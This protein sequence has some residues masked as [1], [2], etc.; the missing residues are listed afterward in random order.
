[1]KK[2]ILITSLIFGFAMQLFAQTTYPCDIT[3][4]GISLKNAVGDPIPRISVGGNGVANFVIT[5]QGVGSNGSPCSYPVGKVKVTVSFV[6]SNY[7]SYFFAYAGQPSF[8]TLKYDWVYD[9][10]N[11]QL[12]G[13]NSVPIPST[14]AGGAEIVNVPIVGIA[15]GTT[16]LPMS[17]QILPGLSGDNTNNNAFDMPVTVVAPT[18]V[19]PVTLGDFNAKAE[20]C[21]TTLKWIATNEV[22]LK[23][24]EVETSV[25]GS[26]FSNIAKVNKSTS[27]NAGEYQF[28]WNQKETKGYYRLKIV[29]NDGSYVYS[30]VISV[31]SDCKVEKLVRVYPNP[32]RTNQLLKVSLTG[33]DSYSKGD[34]FSSTG[35]LVKTF[36][37]KNGNN[38]VAIENLAQGFYIL[39]ISENGVLVE[40]F[41]VNVVK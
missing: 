28:Q 32:V 25:D 18:L 35:Q 1:M 15:E 14:L 5:N 24:Y 9:A 21:V 7:A 41:K 13:Y 17:M 31:L 26:N 37:L 16:L 39:R 40:T 3:S 23:A 12:V 10:V 33:H 30:K 36:L 6:P 19:L 20:N 4:T 8:S 38:E 22:N 34:L 11:S 27:S 2:T 29:D